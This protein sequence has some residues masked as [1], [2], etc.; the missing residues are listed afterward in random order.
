M[1]AETEF[2]VNQA[3]ARLDACADA[4]KIAVVAQLMLAIF[5]HFY[6]QL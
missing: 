3:Y 2:R 5:D 1:L 6:C 4:D